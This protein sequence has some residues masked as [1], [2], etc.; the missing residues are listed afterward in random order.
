MKLP[1]SSSLI[2]AT[3]AVSS[4][5]S[6]LAAPTG[7]STQPTS[8]ISTSSS[9]R[10]T[11][12]DSV[13]MPQ[14][15][16]RDVADGEVERRGGNPLCLV[17]PIAEDLLDKVGG[18]VGALPLPLLGN[19]A[20]PII[21]TAKGLLPLVS[22]LADCPPQAA[23]A[24]ASAQG[25]DDSSPNSEPPSDSS[26][27]NSSNGSSSPPLDTPTTP[28]DPPARRGLLVQTP[29]KAPIDPSNSPIQPPHPRPVPVDSPEPSAA[30]DPEPSHLP[31]PPVPPLESPVKPPVGSPGA[32]QAPAAV[33][34]HRRRT[35]PT[36]TE[37]QT[38]GKK[39]WDDA[40]NGD[41]SR[42]TGN[43]TQ[44]PTG[45]NR[46]SRRI[47]QASFSSGASA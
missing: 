25:L 37:K 4:S 24:V 23:M 9:L 22:Q 39:R 30:I 26:F 33:P 14:H 45:P 20:T 8:G 29:V 18:T 12:R 31:Q 35:P 10:S 46:R 38:V 16:T 43:T 2:F 42:R 21:R 1:S 17:M 13:S 44:K 7:D 6:S 28:S 41:F 34:N 5:S 36:R 3:L 19:V 47:S 11:R 32:S 15:V 27:K 40:V